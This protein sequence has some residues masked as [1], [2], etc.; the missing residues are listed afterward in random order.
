MNVTEKLVFLYKTWTDLVGK[1][2][3]SLGSWELLTVLV[4]RIDS[5]AH[6]LKTHITEMR[7]KGAYLKDVSKALKLSQDELATLLSAL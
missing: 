7:R 6:A 3:A 4:R 1:L 5:A 2:P